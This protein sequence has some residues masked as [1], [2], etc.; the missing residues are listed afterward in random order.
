MQTAEEAAQLDTQIKA[1]V[2]N[3]NSASILEGTG[4]EEGAELENLSF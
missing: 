1:V 4:L 3:M 2:D